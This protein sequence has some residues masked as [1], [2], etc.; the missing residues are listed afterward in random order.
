MG[1]ETEDPE[2]D[3]LETDGMATASVSASPTP[4]TLGALRASGWVSRSVRDELR[5]NLLE[6][7]RS[8]GTPAFAPGACRW[9]ERN[10]RPMTR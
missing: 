9:I 10:L 6:R 1:P 2:T 8:L 4:A 7:L 5:E 3:D